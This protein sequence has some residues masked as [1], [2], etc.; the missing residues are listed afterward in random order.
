MFGKINGEGK[1]E[2]EWKS[3]NEIFSEREQY[4]PEIEKQLSTKKGFYAEIE[5]QRFSVD[6]RV[7]CVDEKYDPETK[8][9][10]LVHG[11][12]SSWESIAELGF[13]LACEGR[14]II[15]LSLPG[16]GNSDDPGKEYFHDKEDFSNEAEVLFQMVEQLRNDGVCKDKVHLVS[17]S[18]GCE[19]ATDFSDR[20]PSL[21]QSVVLL[22]P[23]GVRKEKKNPLVLSTISIESFVHSEIEFLIRM[24]FSGEKNY[25][26]KLH[27]HMKEMRSPFERSRLPQR[28]S[29]IKRLSG[30]GR[31]LEKIQRTKVPIGVISGEM[32][33]IFP[34]EEIEEIVRAIDE[35]ML[36]GISIMQS[37]GHILAFAHEITAA[38]VD[39]LLSL[40]EQRK[41]LS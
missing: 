18:M 26:E 29:E 32:D 36:T 35:R 27:R 4:I 25:E 3:I 12:S 9:V 23:A 38:N 10:V 39:H 24:A 40:A 14:K 22:A 2:N 28:V 34:S 21:V 16:Y 33:S 6:Y 17:H 41:H 7:I 5:G 1:K 15:L 37:L 13:S 20:H 8:P 19:I 30:R 11:F 31:L